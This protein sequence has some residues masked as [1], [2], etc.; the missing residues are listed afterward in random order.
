MALGI[1][2]AFKKGI[3]EYISVSED[4]SD[5]GVILIDVREKAVIKAIDFK[6]AHGVS[7]GF[8]KEQFPIKRGD[9][10]RDELIGPA[11]GALTEALARSGYPD[12]RVSVE[13]IREKTKT[14]YRARLRV[15]ISQGRPLLV[16]KIDVI[17]RPAREVIGHL[18]LGPGDVYDQFRIERGMEK[19]KAFYKKRGYFN[20]VIGP[21]SYYEGE[22]YLNVRPGDRLEVSFKGN[23]EFGAGRLGGLMPFM[24][25]GE[26]GDEL[27]EDAVE[28]IRA[29]Y[30]EYGYPYLQVAPVVKT[31]DGLI[32]LRFFI[33]E[34]KKVKVYS[35]NFRGSHLPAKQLKKMLAL[36]EGSPFNP[37]A[38]DDDGQ[39]IKDFYESLGYLDAAVEA[40]DAVRDS[41]AD[42]TFDIQEGKQYTLDSVKLEGVKSFPPAELEK[43]IA[44]V[45]PGGAYNELLLTNAKYAIL[46]F[47]DARGY[48]DCNVDV[49]R[50]FKDYHVSVTFLVTEGMPFRFGKHVIAGNEITKLK[51]FD[52]E[53]A[54]Q[55]GAPFS[56][57]ELLKSRQKLYELGVFKDVDTTVIGRHDGTVDVAYDVKEAN[58]G[59]VEFGVGYGEY[60]KERGFV[61]LSYKDLFGMANLGSLRFDGDT[62]DKRITLNYGSPWFFNWDVPFKAYLLREWRDEKNID[63]GTISYRLSR[64]EANMGVEK[65]LS[66]KLKAEIYYEYSLVSTTDV[67]PDVVLSRQDVGTHS[68]SAVRPALVYDSRDDPFDPHSGV[69]AGAS[70]KLATAYLFSQTN[71]GK[72]ILQ[73]S[74]YVGL[75]DVFV[76]AGSARAGLAEGFSNTNELPIE[77]RFFLGGRDSVRGYDQ[78]TLGPKGAAGDPIGGNAFACYNLELR[79]TV[80]KNWEIVNFVDAGNV[81]FFARE[82]SIRD[83]KY[84]TGLG[85]RY[86]TP[87]GPVRVDYGYKL[88]RLRGESIGALH[89]S[90]GQAF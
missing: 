58:P 29:L 5:P 89:F 56:Q 11:A 60:E 40:K 1:K 68:I 18:G 81:W 46:E 84:T 21:Y 43:L 65:K 23:K 69:F 53:L 72:L 87:V 41:R 12:A 3:F 17:G 75:S 48:A 22:L 27:V 71:F 70:L 33:Y 64:Y 55:D 50:D 77:E 34:G 20:P 30:R 73:A 13:V 51:V 76:L 8:L 49:V 39:R 90:I 59:S 9:F 47:Y 14:P 79:T 6:G 28:S 63:T 38:L 19:L 16:S 57:K 88:S 52:R 4:T 62:L 54:G 86:K 44:G 2:R 25:A 74:K 83:L 31:E 78:D 36:E 37:A 45:R 80:K 10:L 35:I 26:F 32:L 7:G 24:E 61:Q 85:L 66:G 15:H 42:I 82:F 67:A